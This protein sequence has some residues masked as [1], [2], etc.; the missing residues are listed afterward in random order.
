MFGDLSGMVLQQGR[1]SVKRFAATVL[2]IFAFVT[3]GA[4]HS[5]SGDWNMFVSPSAINRI[6]CLGDSIWCATRGGI[7]IFNRVDS[8]FVQHLDGLGFRSTDVSGVTRDRRG[9][10]WASFTTSGVARIDHLEGDPSVKL[11]S[12][13][14]DGLMSD[15]ITCIA[16]AGEDVYYGSVNGVAKFYDNLHSYEPN[17]TDSLE[18]TAVN[19]LLANGDT[20]W[21]ACQKG[22]ALFQRSILSFRMFRMGN[23]TS[24]CV[25][26]GAVCCAGTAGVQRFNGS[27]WVSLGL[28]GGSVPRAVASGS[29]KLYCI[30]DVRVY[31][32]SGSAWTNITRN[33]GDIYWAKYLIGSSKTPLRT[34]AVDSRDAPWV[35]GLEESYDRGTYLSAFV[36]NVWINKAPEHLSQNNIISLAFS[37]GQ[38][39]WASTRH[40]G[41]TFRS[42]DGRWISYTKVRTPTN[43]KG[44]S[45]RSNHTALLF[46]SQG[47]LWFNALDYDLDRIKVNDPFDTG[48]DEWAHFALNTE[49]ITSNRFIKAK[50]D[51]AGNRW[52]LSDDDLQQQGKLGINILSANGTSWLN[53]IP[54]AGGMAGGSVFDCAFGTG[55]VVYL[56]LK[57]YGVQAWYTGGFDWPH[58]SDLSNDIWRTIIR[59]DDL[60][61]K[62]LF[63]IELGGDGAVWLGTASGLV[64]YASGAV[65]SIT[66]KMNP[67]ERGLIGAK[68]YDLEFDGR[69]KLWVSTDQ[70]LNR[71]DQSGNIDAFTTSDA[72]RGD[73]YPSSVIVPLPSA[74]CGALYYD[75]AAEALW[76]GTANGLARLDVSP[77]VKEE[78]PLARMI[79]YPN[80]VHLSRGDQALRIARISSPVS[81]RVYTLEG[82]L[83]HEADRVEEK[84]VAWDLLTLNGF[85]ARSGVYIVRV[86][87]GRTSEVRKIG[88]IR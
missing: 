18:G 58:L 40:Y 83:V 65:D 4:A 76:I 57:G 19:D 3:P 56:A 39:L 64:R 63:A 26:D 22:V 24:L 27:T 2:A 70:G 75:G 43:D 12:A 55:G 50:E 86:I 15:S 88:I 23:V 35:A 73:L 1:F 80:P 45:Y 11:Y 38:G 59:P 20:L 7:L 78:V 69:G 37:P 68:A 49:T 60:A 16:S 66:M 30:T 34:I 71:I 67:G 85:K 42:N 8:T 13:T 61:S 84:G 36:N 74:S 21:V 5:A 46:D 6:V 9:S 28:P 62:D 87:S 52:F 41:I 53:I 81:I 33:L 17:L 29:R 72:W 14:I 31:E 82:E 77:P 44:L 32:W 54:T 48:D 10:V 51:P 25:H 47:Y 79:L